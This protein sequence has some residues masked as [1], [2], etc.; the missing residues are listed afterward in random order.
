MTGHDVHGKAVF[1]SDGAP[2]V[3]IDNEALK[4]D[5]FEL[6]N[7]DASPAPIAAVED[8]PTNRPV[9]IPPRERG[10]IIRL[11][12][13]HPNGPNVVSSAST[14]VIA[15]GFAQFGSPGAST[16]S[17]HSAH[18]QMHRTQTIDYGI[19][20]EGELF[21]VLDDSETLIKAGDVVV[22]RGTNHA[23]DN[24]SNGICRMAFILLDGVYEDELVH[25]FDQGS[26]AH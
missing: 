12:D 8:E 3:R 13:F 5:L 9:N 4:V 21:L 26:A 19:V 10:S 14:K 23:W 7:T 17:S 20:L 11:A 25:S 16:L 6:W 24:R 1:L 18:P 2:P 22:Q 15:E